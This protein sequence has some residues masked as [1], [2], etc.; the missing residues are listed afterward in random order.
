M[1]DP[2][3]TDANRESA[4]AT[5]IDDLK[6]AQAITREIEERFRLLVEGA[7]D[8]AMFL[9]DPDNTITFWNAGAEKV[10]GWG[11]EEA[12]GR[13][14]DLVFTPEDRAKG[15]VEKELI[16]AS[17]VGRAPDRRWHLRKDGSRFWV[18]GVM[19]RLDNPDGTLRGFAKIARDATEL[20]DS[21]EQLRHSRDEMEQRVVE[22]TAELMAS[23]AELQNEI[24]MR[25]QLE[26]TSRD[27]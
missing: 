5:D 2:A 4:S 7:P 18:D 8:Y 25:Q 26:R 16:I 10:F 17:E 27:Q 14:G 6:H 1:S 21:E 20:H 23:N 22:R 11:A 19:R 15:A 12:V 13:T 24:H 3:A 9:L